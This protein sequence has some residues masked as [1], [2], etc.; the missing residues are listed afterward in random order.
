VIWSE[1]YCLGH[2]SSFDSKGRQNTNNRC[3]VALAVLSLLVRA[4]RI[5]VWEH[6]DWILER[7]RNKLRRQWKPLPTIIKGKKGATLVL[8]TAKLLHREKERN[9]SLCKILILWWMRHFP[10]FSQK[11]YF[12]FRLNFYL[13]Y[14]T[15]AN[16]AKWVGICILGIR[17][18]SF[19]QSSLWQWCFSVCLPLCTLW[20]RA[21]W[22]GSPHLCS[23]SAQTFHYVQNLSRR[24][25]LQSTSQIIRLSHQSSCH[26]WTRPPCGCPQVQAGSIKGATADAFHVC[27]A[28]YWASW[29]V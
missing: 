8:S 6:V 16:R 7:R 12:V 2:S 3:V 13:Y 17:G 27:V 14:W 5:A 23:T 20:S 1:D 18:S 24:L 9:I 10:P 26:R 22:V 19:L 15:Q 28:C 25:Q 4:P 29:R 21:W 11:L